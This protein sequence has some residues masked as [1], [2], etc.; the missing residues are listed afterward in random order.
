MII[1]GVHGLAPKPK[2]LQLELWW[3][4]CILDGLRLNCGVEPDLKFE[5]VYWADL[6]HD[7]TVSYEENEEPYIPVTGAG[8]LPTYKEGWRDSMIAGALEVGGNSLDWAKRHFGLGALADAVLKSKLNDLS[9]YYENKKERMAMCSQLRVKLF[10]HRDKRITL[11]AHS[12]GSIIAY[13][14]LREIGRNSLMQGFQLAHFITIGSPLGLPHVTTKIWEHS[15]L[16]R[17]PSV[18]QKWTNLSDRGDMVCLDAHLADDFDPN[19][20]GVQ[21]EDHLVLNGYVGLKGKANHHKAYGYLRTREF[22]EFIL[23]LL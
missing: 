17:T 2:K 22:S 15:H 3:R 4:K 14:V 23:R 16:V 12:M 5:M 13:D 18:V 10:D 8:K 20:A 9:R 19:D 11:I 6:L 1:L 21:V 7:K